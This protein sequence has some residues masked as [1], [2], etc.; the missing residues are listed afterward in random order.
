ME[1]LFPPFCLLV[2]AGIPWL[3]S[4]HFSLCSNFTLPSLL[5]V[6]NLLCTLSILAIGFRA[7][8]GNPGESPYQDP[9]CNPICSDSFPLLGNSYRL[10]GRGPESVG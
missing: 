3:V 9:Y 8:P 5:F 4:H 10:H 1:G 6:S 7:C 2:A